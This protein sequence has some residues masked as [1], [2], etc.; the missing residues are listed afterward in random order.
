MR[1]IVIPAISLFALITV[2]PLVAGTWVI[3][4][5]HVA[6]LAGFTGQNAAVVLGGHTPGVFSGLE[7]LETGDIIMITGE[8]GTQR[9]MITWI[10][11]APDNSAD[12]LFGNPEADLIIVTCNGEGRR[13]IGAKL[14]TN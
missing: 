5:N 11:V 9:Y 7:T 6:E 13:L 14:Q 12:W 10:N 8:T 1:H 4:D 3:P 2:A